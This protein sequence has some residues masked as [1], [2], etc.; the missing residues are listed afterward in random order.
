MHDLIHHTRADGSPYPAEECRFYQ[1][2]HERRSCCISTTRL[3]GD[4]TAPAS[5]RNAG[6]LRRKAATPIVGAVVTFVDITERKRK[7]AELR[8]LT[9]VV[10]QSPATIV[11][12]DRNG[13]IEY[14][15]PKFT[16][17]TGYTFAEAKGKNPRILKSGD[18]PPEEY[19]ASLGDHHSPATNGT[20]SST[21]SRKDGSLYWEQA[22][23]APVMNAKGDI[24]NFIA[25]KED[26][27]ERKKIEA[28]L[29]FDELRLESLLRISQH[30]AASTKELLDFALEEAIRL[31][32]SK[33]G[34]LFQY[35]DEQELLTL[36]SWSKEAMRQCQTRRQADRL[37][38]EE[39]RP[40]GRAD[41]AAK[42]DHRQRLP[43]APSAEEG[44]S[45][46]TYR[47]QELPDHSRVH[48]RRN[49][50]HRGRRQQGLR[51]RRVRRSP[52]DALDEL[53][54]ERRR[55]ETGRRGT[56]ETPPGKSRISTR[57][58]PADTT[59]STPTASSCASTT[60]NSAW[61]GYS[62]EEII[63]KKKFSDLV[64]PEG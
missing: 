44:L 24:T 13:D 27:T 11:V 9:V 19:A 45:R 3:S 7:E 46:R 53:R 47:R 36:T 22:V 62:R 60:P 5:P 49:R 31:T 25:V 16:E 48:A 51:L 37:R 18:M 28:Q 40:V 63:G 58:R 2:V 20:G 39:H 34:Y 21:T 35:D 30:K 15:N 43:G 59:R 12:T 8:K 50:G 56:G 52:T 1:A 26:I 17:V 29:A 14:V 10:E 64:T 54:L 23:I 6:P 33:I 61:L 55:A 41:P 42:A 4:R 57:R 32:G 38:A